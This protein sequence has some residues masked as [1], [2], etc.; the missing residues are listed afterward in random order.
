[1]N[2]PFENQPLQQD[3]PFK[4]NGRFGRLSYAAWTFL[5]TLTLAAVVLL[6]FTFGLT[7]NEGTPGFTA[8]GIVAIA[9]LYIGGIYISFVFTIRVCMTVIIQVGYLT[10]A[11]TS[12]EHGL[13]IYLFCAKGTEG[14]NDYGPKRPTPSWERVL[15]WIYIAL[16]PLAVIFL[17]LPQSWLLPMKAML[18]KAKALSLGRHL[19]L[20]NF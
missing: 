10:H 14:P 17:L 6:I 2:S 7:Q 1:M 15:G 16:I 19:S 12:R 20:N 13:A 5:F 8:P 18:K 3:S 9:I 11:R 4:A